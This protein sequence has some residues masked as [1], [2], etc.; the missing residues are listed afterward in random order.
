M[1]FD[2]PWLPETRSEMA[3]PL[4]ARGQVIG[5]MTTQSADAAAFNEDDI[6]VLQTMADQLANAIQNARLFEEHARRTEE[7]AALNYIS[8]AVNRSLE[9]QDMLDA[10]LTAFITVTGYDA[11]LISLSDEKNGQLYVASHQGLPAQMIARLEQKGLAG[12]LCDVVFQTG[13][14]LALGDV[15]QEAQGQVAR[16]Y[17]D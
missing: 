4:T 14:T 6:S 17:P 12:T 9:M 2:N 16:R 3:L 7:L 5:A 8:T 1:R 10:V 15:C 13:E 11:G